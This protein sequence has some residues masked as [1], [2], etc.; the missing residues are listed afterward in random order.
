MEPTKCPKCKSEDVRCWDERHH[1]YELHEPDELGNTHIQVPVGFLACNA[2]QYAWIDA[3]ELS[4]ANYIG[5]DLDAGF[6]D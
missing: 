3:P 4:D 6:Y 2:C 5:D 1:W